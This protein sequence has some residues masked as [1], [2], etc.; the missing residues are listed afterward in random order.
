[1]TWYI[2]Q[3]E[4]LKRD[5]RVVFPFYQSVEEDYGPD[6][7]IFDDSLIHSEAIRAVKNPTE[8]VTKG[9]CSLKAD[10]RKIP[11]KHFLR[12]TA[13]DRRPYYDIRY[14]L[15][16]TVQSAAMKFSLEI[17]GK[18]LGSVEASYE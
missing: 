10:L 2:Y 18:E 11:R 9:N 3:G 15:A 6:D 12:R 17:D 16:V 14:D 7:L 13:P 8:G 5:Q 1:M 4:D